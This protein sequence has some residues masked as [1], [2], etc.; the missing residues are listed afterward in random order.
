MLAQRAEGTEFDAAVKLWAPVY[1]LVV[2]WAFQVLVE[3]IELS[4]RR[5]AEEALERHPVPRP[6][7]RPR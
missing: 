5:V 4:V 6:L 3:R 7:R 1:P 2:R